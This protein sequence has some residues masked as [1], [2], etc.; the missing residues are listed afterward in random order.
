MTPSGWDD[1]EDRQ[2]LE[3]A[4]YDRALASLA[5]QEFGGV[6]KGQLES[7]KAIGILQHYVERLLKF[8]DERTEQ[9]LDAYL[10]RLT[11]MHGAMC[12]C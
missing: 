12:P 3:A 8:E 10:R 11:F 1:T 7:Q 5:A 2:E 4:F 9:Y 6:T